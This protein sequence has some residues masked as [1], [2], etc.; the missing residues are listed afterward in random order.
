VVTRADLEAFKTKVD[1]LVSRAAMLVKSGVPENKLLVQLNTSDLGWRFS[2]TGERLD[3]FYAEL[4][5]SK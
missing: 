4:S 1:A 2:F 5:R 3:H